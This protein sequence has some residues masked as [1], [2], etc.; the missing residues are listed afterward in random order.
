MRQPNR[1]MRGLDCP[2]R[3]RARLL[4][5]V[6]EKPSKLNGADVI[7]PDQGFPEQQSR[8]TGWKPPGWLAEFLL[9]RVVR[10]GAETISHGKR[11]TVWGTKG[12]VQ[13]SS[14]VAGVRPQEIL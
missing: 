9:V 3:H 11:S 8:P 5:Q 10:V 7:P 6:A 2:Y 1:K 4:P 13:R 12:E 14:E